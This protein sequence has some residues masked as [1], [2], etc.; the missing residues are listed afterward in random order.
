[1][2]VS[3]QPVYRAYDCGMYWYEIVEACFAGNFYTDLVLFFFSD[4]TAFLCDGA[5]GLYF[6]SRWSIWILRYIYR[7]CRSG[8]WRVGAIHAYM[9]LKWRLRVDDKHLITCRVWTSCLEWSLACNVLLLG[10]CG[11]SRQGRA[12]LMWAPS[13]WHRLEEAVVEVLSK[14]FGR[15]ASSRWAISPGSW[16]LHFVDVVTPA[17]LVP[18]TKM[19]KTRNDVCNTLIVF[20]F[21]LFHFCM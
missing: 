19:W 3:F 2:R 10:S 11:I 4:T 15:C 14:G 17:R 7:G 6:P 5:W 16:T 20:P 1:M 13:W 18:K 12:V 8:G 9:Y 21:C